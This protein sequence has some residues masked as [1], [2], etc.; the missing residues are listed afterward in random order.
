MEFTNEILFNKPLEAGSTVIIT[1]FGKLYREH[2]QAVSIVF[3]YGENWNETDNA[4][5]TETENGFEV[6]LTIKDYDTF[7]FCFTNSFNIWDNNSGFNYIASIA[8]KK[9]EIVEEQQEN[10]NDDD[11]TPKT[12]GFTDS[13]EESSTATAEEAIEE[14]EENEETQEENSAEAEN[15]SATE[16]QIASFENNENNDIEAAFS[17][18]LDSILDDTTKEDNVD[19]SNLSGFGLQSVDEIKEEDIVNCDKIFAELFE[20]LTV[21]DEKQQ[22]IEK[23]VEVSVPEE[24]ESREAE[25]VDYDKYDAQELDSLMD[26]LLTSIS[27][28]SETA[29][30]ATP[31][32]QEASN[33]DLEDEN[34]GLPAVREDADWVDKL[35]NISY[36]FSQKIITAFKRLGSFI[37]QNLGFAGDDK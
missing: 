8:P 17:S 36:S 21:E 26:N 7:N 1:Y 14:L 23:V 5:M 25:I 16:D 30:F 11:D 18:L 37:K 4:L 2:S 9:N 10:I 3:G 19:V 31:I 29:S 28:D 6:T 35:V 13:T 34:V 33:E 20:D 15:E 24:K 32:F 27:E 22:P 12:D